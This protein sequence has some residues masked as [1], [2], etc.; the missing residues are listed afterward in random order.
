MTRAAL[1]TM[2]LVL[3]PFAVLAND[4]APAC[5][6]ERFFAP[7]DPNRLAPLAAPH[8][9][10][11]AEI[12]KA[13]AGNAVAQRNLGVSYAVGYLVDACE[14]RAEHWFS[15]AAKGGDKYAKDW[16]ARRDMFERFRHGPECMAENCP[17]FE[18]GPIAM[19]LGSDRNGHFRT[20][21]TINNATV[22]ALV[23]TG[24]SFV[25]MGSA[26]AKQM[27]I[28]Y[29]H[30]RTVTMN[31]ANGQKIAKIVTVD[32]VR[33]GNIVLNNVGVAVSEVDM[34]VLLG[35]SFLGRLNMNVGQGRLT[36]ARP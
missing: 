13:N 31:T 23:D 28:A 26:V 8:A 10:L 25:S 16:L 3:F 9:E 18:E 4:A 17:A 20:P 21:L 5:E 7:G 1:A 15:R 34:P 32:R 30:G 29:E 33:A 2:F 11:R 12:H 24:A 14:A 36:L 27:G 19:E 35:M 22:M 6:S